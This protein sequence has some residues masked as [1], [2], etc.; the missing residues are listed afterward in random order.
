MPRKP[1]APQP[2]LLG[3]DRN[4]VK[5][6]NKGDGHTPQKSMQSLRDAAR[7]IKAKVLGGPNQPSPLTKLSNNKVEA[8]DTCLPFFKQ[9]L[10]ENWRNFVT[11]PAGVQGAHQEAGTCLLYTSD[12]ADE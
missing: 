6:S 7:T 9:A 12:A 1:P 4:K 10:G 2:T 5:F 8:A 11:D 3:R